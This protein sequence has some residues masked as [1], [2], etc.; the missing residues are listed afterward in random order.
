MSHTTRLALSLLLAT[1]ILGVVGDILL[2][3]TPWGINRLL[4]VTVLC[5]GLV[6]VA[7]WH[8]L[9]LTGGGRWLTGPAVIFA[10][11]FALRDSILLNSANLLA[12]LIC[13]ALLAYRAV[14]GRIRVAA[15]TEY[16]RGTALAWQAVGA[17]WNYLQGVACPQQNRGTDGRVWGA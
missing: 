12:I 4:W 16:V 5:E 6:A 17:N 9:R 11:M 15:V 3:Q 13:L 8:N 7:Q 10:A 14:P 2:R 1:L